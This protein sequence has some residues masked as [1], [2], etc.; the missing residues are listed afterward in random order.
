MKIDFLIIYKNK[1]KL[2][3]LFQNSDTPNLEWLLDGLPKSVQ[4]NIKSSEKSKKL[5]LEYLAMLKDKDELLLWV[6]KT[7]KLSSEYVPDD[8]V[9]L[10][11]S[12]SSSKSG[13]QLRSV[14]LSDLKAMF[15]SASTQ[16]AT[17]N[18][19]SSYRSYKTQKI[20]FDGWVKKFGEKEARRVSAE[21]GS[22]QHQLGTAI[23][24]NNLDENFDKTKE[25]IWLAQNSHKFGFIISF[26]KGDEEYTGFK[27][28]PWHY[29]YVGKEASF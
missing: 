10:D 23:D 27:Y 19:I 6:N 28:E 4:N 11:T 8:L 24:F 17:L 12:F 22:S 29:R 7:N 20:V 18:I 21:P 9:V 15:E 16:G 5:F 1:L 13:L 3:S 2:P 14:V 26:P 25:G